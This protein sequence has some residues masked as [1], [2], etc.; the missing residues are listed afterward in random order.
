MVETTTDGYKIAIS[1]KGGV[2]KTT[3]ATAIGRLLGRMGRKVLLLDCDPSPNLA[4]SLGIPARDRGNIIPLCHMSQLIAMRTGV[5]VGNSQGKMY[6]LNP[7]VDD[8]LA[9]YGIQ[10]ADGVSL[11]VLGTINTGGSGCFC[12]ES[13]LLK[14]LVNHLVKKDH[15]LLMDMEAG[16][17]HLGRATTR[18]IDLLLIIVEPGMR[19]LETAGAIK[20]LG[21]DIGIKKF[22]AILNKCR[23]GKDENIVRQKLESMDIELIGTIPFSGNIM[24]A[25]LSGVSVMDMEGNEAFVQKIQNIIKQIIEQVLE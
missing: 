7:K 16:I 18:N 11:L 23:S 25:D 24:G 20:D 2:G 15:I 13:A 4:I 9:E 8:I 10:G 14:R 5:E 17:E 3:I 6:T 12:P 21:T 22:C 19:S 1:G